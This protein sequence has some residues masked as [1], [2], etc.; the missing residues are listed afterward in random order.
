M[1]TRELYLRVL[2]TCEMKESE[3]LLL[4]GDAVR[5]LLSL[6]PHALLLREGGTVLGAPDSLDEQT[7]LDPLY[8]GALVAAVI[9]AKTGDAEAKARGI[10]EADGAFREMWRRAAARRRE[11]VRGDAV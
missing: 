1:N 5:S 7:G 11:A 4:L 9:A 8:D 6:Y 2:G 10:R 3:F